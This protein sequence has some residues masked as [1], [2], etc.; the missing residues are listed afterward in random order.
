[1]REWTDFLVAAAGASSALVGLLF[2]GLSINLR[3]I[4]AN[5]QLPSRAMTA[6]ILLT[7]VLLVSLLGLVPGQSASI[8]GGE[9][10]VLGALDWLGGL[11]GL[12]PKWQYVRS[13]GRRDTAAPYSLAFRFLLSHLATLPYCV[14]GILFWLGS[15]TAPYWLV[16]AFLFSIFTAI[17]DAWVLLIEINR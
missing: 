1:M 4:L 10:F 12:W 9:T 7:T 16:P 13:K 5:R 8:F 3:K 14:A 17:Y 6:T 2:V 11:S 15:A